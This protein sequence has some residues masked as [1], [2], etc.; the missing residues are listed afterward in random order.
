MV[1][2]G[3]GEEDLLE[4]FGFLSKMSDGLG[5]PPDL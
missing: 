3:D 5:V 4:E 1:G 2:L